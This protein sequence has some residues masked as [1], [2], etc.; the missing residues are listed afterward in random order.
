MQA[1]GTARFIA[2]V[3]DAKLKLHDKMPVT[4]L[5]RVC[6][7]CRTSLIEVVK[8]REDADDAVYVKDTPR[9]KQECP[10]E[11]E[12]GATDYAKT[13]SL[14][15]WNHLTKKFDVTTL[16][17][18]LDTDGHLRRSLCLIGDPGAGKSRLMHMIGVEMMV[19]YEKE[20]YVFV[21]GLD[22]LG[23]LSH[24]GVVRKA[25]AVFVTDFDMKARKGPLSMEEKKGVLDVLEGASITATGY[26]P[27]V[28]P[29][30]LPRMLSV[31]GDE[32]NRGSWFI[33]N[34]LCE[35]GL[36]ASHLGSGDIQD[37]VSMAT[38]AS[39]DGAAILRRVAFAFVE[40]PLVT[41]EAVAT[42]ATDSRQRAAEGLARRKARSSA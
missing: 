3:E 27:A 5:E 19:A 33:K 8:L 11:F 38:S 42:L 17:E 23:I 40:N 30:Q 14:Y 34:D 1:W 9:Q 24:C 12:E 13:L 35:I 32:G 37:A 15:N 20:L 2:F 25:A 41:E 21:K 16:S 10:T 18:W 31:N 22:Q 39:S 28:F 6:H 26:R 7:A 4:Q 29:P 36:I